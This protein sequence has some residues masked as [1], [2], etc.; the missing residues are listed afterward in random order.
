MVRRSS[1][2]RCSSER[3][4]ASSP[5]VPVKHGE[6]RHDSLGGRYFTGSAY[7]RAGPLVPIRG[8]IREVRRLLMYMGLRKHAIW[9]DG[10]VETPAMIDLDSD[11]WTRVKA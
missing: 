10:P 8:A 4:M 3:A 11:E 2:R 7:R 5:P 1:S 6:Q 9:I